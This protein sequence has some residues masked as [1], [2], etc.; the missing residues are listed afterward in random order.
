MTME[1]DKTIILSSIKNIYSEISL[2]TI[3]C[4]NQIVSIWKNAKAEEIL[5][6]I[7]LDLILSQENFN[8]IK[9]LITNNRPGVID[10][11]FL[12]FFGC[13]INIVPIIY[14]NFSGAILMF[15]VSNE[16]TQKTIFAKT[17][18][19]VALLSSNL[20]LPM[21]LITNAVEILNYDINKFQISIPNKEKMQKSISVVENNT[22]K[23]YRVCKNLSELIRF[24][25]NSNCFNKS[26]VK[27]SDYINNLIDS[28]SSY[29]KLAGLNLIYNFSSLSGATN[30]TLLDCEKFDLAI[31][32][33]ILNSCQ[34]SLKNKNIFINVTVSENFLKLIIRDE[35]FGIPQDKIRDIFRPY[36]TLKNKYYVS[37]GLGIG[38]TLAQY[39]INKHNGFIKID[40]EEDV[41]TTVTIEIPIVFDIDSNVIQ[42]YSRVSF[43]RKMSTVD[44]QFSPLL[45]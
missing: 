40:S 1:H 4:D 11:C 22:Y 17:D 41:G 27:I 26:V 5:N 45:Y 37:K 44:I 2:P 3:V 30:L 42:I 34:Y 19:M 32:N 12:P 14:N 20:R 35:G 29:I 21:H 24:S 36:T 15:Q 6:K 43:K 7:N 8:N 33:I 38:L 10:A 28:C 25:T 18:N 31:S 13:V 39:I 9:D 23:I 16:E